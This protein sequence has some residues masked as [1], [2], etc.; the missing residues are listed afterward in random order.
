[1]KLLK[2]MHLLCSGGVSAYGYKQAGFQAV[3]GNDI[4]PKALE[5]YKNNISPHIICEDFTKVDWWKV[6]QELECQGILPDVLEAGLVCHTFS[7]SFHGDRWNNRETNYIFKMIDIIKFFRFPVIQFEQSSRITSF[8]LNPNAPKGSFLKK[9][10]ETFKK[11]LPEYKVR[12]RVID[13]REFG[14][15]QTRQRWICILSRIG[16]IEIPKPTHNVNDFISFNE[17]VQKDF[18]LQDGEDNLWVDWEKIEKIE[19]E[20]RKKSRNSSWINNHT[21]ESCGH[22][23][24]ANPWGVSRD[25][26]IIILSPEDKYVRNYTRQEMR[27]VQG[28]PPNFNLEGLSKTQFGKIVG[29]AFPTSISFQIA[30]AIKQKL[31]EYYQNK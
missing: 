2:S 10:L 16:A 6:K 11:E 3:L 24:T 19:R 30:L 20:R 7:P 23:I 17:I 27:R 29:N 1:M 5:V 12:W 4:D 26:S 15:S 9:I 22:T 31:N 21:L 8:R 14:L 13:A 18:T 28:I 25:K